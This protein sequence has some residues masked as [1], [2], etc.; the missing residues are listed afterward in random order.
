MYVLCLLSKGDCEPSW[1][2]HVVDIY[3]DKLKNSHVCYEV[4]PFHYIL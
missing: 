3:Y 2:N 1:F 4:I